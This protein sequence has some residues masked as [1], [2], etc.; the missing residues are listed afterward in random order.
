MPVRM[1]MVCRERREKSSLIRAVVKDGEVLADKTQKA[2]QRGF[3]ICPEC[4]GDMQKKRV[5]ERVLKHSAGP[6]MY[7][8][9]IKEAAD[10]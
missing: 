8:R 6:G 7:E 5:F 9:F 1:C 10:V 4:L 3:Y 2:Q